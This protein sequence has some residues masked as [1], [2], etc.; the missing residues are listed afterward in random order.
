[1]PA[2]I[3]LDARMIGPVMTGLGRYA[4][5][6]A[7][8]LPGL[9]PA[10]RYVIIHRAHGGPRLQAASTP[11]NVEFAVVEGDLDQPSNL[12]AAR[13][14]NRLD[15]DVYHSLYDFV[16]PGLRVRKVVLTLHD[17]TWLEAPDLCFDERFAW[18]KARVTH[19]YARL[20][21]PYAVRKAAHV[22][23]VSSH[24]RERA[25]AVLGL[26]PDR[27]TVIHHGVARDDFPPAATAP[28]A[29]ERSSSGETFFLC[30][31]NT[32]PYKN[33]RAAISAF[34]LIAGS[35]AGCRLFITGRTDSQRN[36][37]ALVRDLGLNGRVSF[38]GAVPQ[39]R[40]VELMHQAVGLVF[41]SLVEGF[42]LPLV[43]A[44]SAGCPV[45]G[46]SAPTVA[47]ICGD[48]A[49]LPDPR[50]PVAVAEAMRRLLEDPPLRLELRRKG[51]ARA[52]LFTWDACARA[53]LALYRSLEE[54]G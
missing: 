35:H 49:L 32:K 42:G 36:L 7:T 8:H 43:E 6:L 51:F 25:I 17:L 18:T 20:T 15:L 41:P 30:L 10:T 34:A 23:A 31:G 1:M 39:V 19:A 53:T 14:I 11:S 28:A 13:G 47:E 40:L 33:T 38:T 16:P 9:D 48:A 27:V 44:M 5:G 54:A 21:M 52:A 37:E 3:G 29:G 4:L 45:V 22:I 24:T 50:S 12:F 2:R 26:S 46:S